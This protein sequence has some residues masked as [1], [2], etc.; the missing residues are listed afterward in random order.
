MVVYF[1]EDP[2]LEVSLYTFQVSHCQ[3]Q[4]RMQ[5]FTIH[6]RENTTP[7]IAAV[8]FKNAPLGIVLK[9]KDHGA[10]LNFECEGFHDPH[11]KVSNMIV[12][13]YLLQTLLLILIHDWL[14]MC[15]I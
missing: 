13:S 3:T 8:T 14:M 4:T 7:L 5:Y 9:L 1:P 10:D 15:L 2:L 12:R 6:R 11:T